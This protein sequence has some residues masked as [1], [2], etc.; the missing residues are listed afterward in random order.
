MK[1]NI[2]DK[3]VEFVHANELG[4]DVLLFLVL[5]RLK[6]A[7]RDIW[8][9]DGLHRNRCYRRNNFYPTPTSLFEGRPS[10][11]VCQDESFSCSPFN[12][13]QQ[14]RNGIYFTS[15]LVTTT[16]FIAFLFTIEDGRVKLKKHLVFDPSSKNQ[17]WAK[18]YWSVNFWDE[19]EAY[20]DQPKTP[21]L[22]GH[23]VLGKYMMF[24]EDDEVL[25]NGAFLKGAVNNKLADEFQKFPGRYLAALLELI[26][27]FA[28]VGVDLQHS[29]SPVLFLFLTTLTTERLKE[30]ARNIREHKKSTL[31]L[32]T[33]DSDIDESLMNTGHR[34][35][36]TYIMNVS[37]YSHLY[38]HLATK[39][40]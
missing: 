8:R 18:A 29:D 16:K 21:E 9:V 2:F 11:F 31:L 35:N 3:L 7:R 5:L 37:D 38:F 1:T 4:E 27:V 17:V 22:Q 24:P 30:T 6:H 33:N 26:P 34:Y 36:L 40:K 13:G 20:H 32:I 23:R 15:L 12:E 25:P 39:A 28:Y 14:Y 19:I 10:E